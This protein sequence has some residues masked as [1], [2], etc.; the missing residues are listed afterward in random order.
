MHIVYP[1][2][3]KERMEQR[4]ITKQQ[5]VDTVCHPQITC[6]TENKRRKRA[7]RTF[8][9]KTLDVIYVPRGNQ[10]VILVTAV[11]LKKEDRKVG[12]VK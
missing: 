4:G 9:S 7:M 12:D 10:Q 1:V 5:I 2:H 11:W 8:G 3:I 6:P